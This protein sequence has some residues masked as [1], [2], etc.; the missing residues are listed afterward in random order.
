MDILNIREN[1]L[2]DVDV[3]FAG[4][5]YADVCIRWGLYSSANKFATWPIVPGFE[6]SGVVARVGEGENDE[7]DFKVGEK[8]FGVSMFGAY[9]DSVSVPY[10]QLFRL[11]KGLSMKDAAG[12]CTVG[13]T[14]HYAMHALASN[15]VTGSTVLIHSAAGG[16]GSFLVQLAK[17]IG[18]RVVGVVGAA[19]KVAYLKSLNCDHVVCKALFPSPIEWWR[20][21]DAL[22][23]RGFDA[24]FDANGVAT[25]RES[26]ARLAPAGRLVVYG[27][28]TMLP[29]KGGLLGI[30]EWIKLAYDYL[31]SPTFDPLKMTSENK[32]VM[33]FNLSYMFDKRDMLDT[34]M[35]SLLDLHRRKRLKVGSVTVYPLSEAARAH[36][37]IES[38]NT[39]GKLVLDCSK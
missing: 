37:A 27:F 4:V 28:H 20:H 3:R 23:P 10:Y 11:P 25:L 15:V 33:A 13:L 7:H 12:F 29:K 9:S 5:N 19:H 14:A 35:R 22:V 17:A 39:V 38:G 2:I 1:D 24:V 21:I 6:F 31:R 26:Y 36:A 30:R 8:V 18:C 34:T 32:S 16:V